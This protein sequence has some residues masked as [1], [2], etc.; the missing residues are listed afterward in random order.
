[1]REESGREVLP[2]VFFS[3][4]RCCQGRS[5]GRGLGILHGIRIRLR[6]NF[7]T[8]VRTKKAVQ[9]FSIPKIFTKIFQT[10]KEIPK[11]F[12]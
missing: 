6:K 8:I 2:M 9:D 4:V 5:D 10:K 7:E 11:K 3:D 1:M 12:R